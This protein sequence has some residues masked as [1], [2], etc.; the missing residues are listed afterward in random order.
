M[1]RKDF[2]EKF[3]GERAVAA[4]AVLVEDEATGKKRVIHDGSHGARVNHRIRCL[5]KLRMPGGREKRQLLGKFHTARDFSLIGDFRKAHIGDSNIDRT[6][7]GT[8]HAKFQRTMPG[9]M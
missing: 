9:Y 8:W 6:S 1:L 5:D 3:G 4:L 7:M 2:E